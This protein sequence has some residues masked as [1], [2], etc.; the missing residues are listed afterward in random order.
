MTPQPVIRSFP[1]CPQPLRPRALETLA[2]KV[3]GP[4]PQ[5]GPYLQTKMGEIEHASGHLEGFLLKSSLFGDFQVILSLPS[6]GE[7]LPFLV[8][9]NFDGCH[10]ITKLVGRSD[11]GQEWPLLET[12]RQRG[13]D[14]RGWMMEAAAQ[15]GWGVLTACHSTIRLDDPGAPPTT[16]PA[17]SMWA[18]G[19]SL[20][21]QFGSLHPRLNPEAAIA[22]GHSR[23]GKTALWAAAWD[24]GFAG[25]CSIQSGCGGAAP[26][27][28]PG[29]ET[30][31][32]ITSAFPHWFVHS[33]SYWAGREAEMPWDQNW[34]LAL[35]APRPLLILNAEEDRWAD[36]EGQEDVCRAVSS[37]F[38]PGRLSRRTRAGTHQVTSEDWAAVL[39]FFDPLFAPA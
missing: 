22:C 8:W 36:P 14:T 7:N 16:S 21:R 19:M 2:E 23:L 20:L 34:L 35:L 38:P 33:L 18:S 6:K 4:V 30:V 9:L 3:Y 28:S 24:E 37:L 29:G 27:R 32:Q 17:I 31:A 26:F 10:T 5:S 13:N 39:D 1:P 25:A 11:N 15:R 12:S